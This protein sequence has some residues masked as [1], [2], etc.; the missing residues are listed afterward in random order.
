MTLKER[1]RQLASTLPS[2]HSAVTFTRADLVA[3]L[4]CDSSETGVRSTR[5]LTVAE[6]ADETGR[7]PSTVR[8]W[9][10]SDALRGYKLNTRYRR[11]PRT[12]LRQYLDAQTTGA[13]LTPGNVDITAWRNGGGYMIGP[14]RIR[15]Q[16]S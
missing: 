13:T 2:D 4:E 8:G 7:A 15:L 12:A 3:L 11:V 16:Q 6:L 10:I 9:L 1:L 5:D 14:G